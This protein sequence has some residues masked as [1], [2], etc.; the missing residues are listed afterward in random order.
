MKYNKKLLD[1]LKTEINFKDFLIEFGYISPQDIRNSYLNSESYMCRTPFGN[2]K[3][4]SFAI[5]KKSDGVWVWYDFSVN[6][7]T[8]EGGTIIDFI[9]KYH[10]Y[11]LSE[12]INFLVEKLGNRIP[13]YL[14]DSETYNTDY[15]NTSYGKPVRLVKKEKK[16]I[17]DPKESLRIYNELTEEVEKNTEQ[18]LQDKIYINTIKK[19]K[20]LHELSDS[21]SDKEILAKVKDYYI[22]QRYID[23]SLV[24]YLIENKKVVYYKSTKN[25]EYAGFFH[26]NYLNLRAIVPCAKEERFRNRG[27]V[28][29]K[30]F[31]F[32]T[33]AR[34]NSGYLNN[35]QLSVFCTEGIIDTLSICTLYKQ[36]KELRKRDFLTKDVMY[37]SFLS[38]SNK[39]GLLRFLHYLYSN[40]KNKYS[41]IYLYNGFDM[42][43][44]GKKFFEVMKQYISNFEKN[45]FVIADHYTLKIT[46]E[47]YYHKYRN[48]DTIKIKDFNDLLQFLNKNQNNKQ[49]NTKNNTFKKKQELLIQPI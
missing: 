19:L 36:N 18:S 22:N 25:I 26:D 37:I 9:Q 1:Y 10:N 12:S 49:K 7:I 38:V 31:G 30:W 40:F 2:E 43:D 39:Q 28:K 35:N 17:K 44:A 42:D 34:K 24:D 21:K 29:G 13:P 41:K 11:S 45:Y 8:H 6:G 20:F 33:T 15:Q 27:S 3:T 47:E 5:S 32:T 14:L 48:S 4:P 16:I 23:K 46:L